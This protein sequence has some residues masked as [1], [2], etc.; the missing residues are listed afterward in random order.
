MSVADNPYSVADHPHSV[1]DHPYSPFDH[2]ALIL[3]LNEA[4]MKPDVNTVILKSIGA[5]K[6]MY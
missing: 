1:T 6:K 3:T 4:M 2:S 5:K